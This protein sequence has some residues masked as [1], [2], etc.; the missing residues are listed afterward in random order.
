MS[1]PECLSNIGVN[2]CKKI[3]QCLNVAAYL[4]NGDLIVCNTTIFA[5]YV[6]FFLK[7]KFKLP[8]D[9]RESL[10]FVGYLI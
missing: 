2:N 10:F 6:D 5:K 4:W 9:S 3:C 1:Q 8:V 7:H